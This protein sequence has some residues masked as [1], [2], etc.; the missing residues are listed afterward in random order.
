MNA[1]HAPF[2]YYITDT[3]DGEIKGTND[4]SVA[5]DFS[6][7]EDYFVVCVATNQWLRADGERVPVA[8]INAGGN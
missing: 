6:L 1:Q 2:S 4:E 8:D 5:V 3:M 7:S